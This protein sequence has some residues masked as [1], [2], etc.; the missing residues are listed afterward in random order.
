MQLGIWIKQASEFDLRFQRVIEMGIVFGAGSDRFYGMDTYENP[1]KYLKTL[2]FCSALFD[3][4]NPFQYVYVGRK[5]PPLGLLLQDSMC[6]F[7]KI[8]EIDSNC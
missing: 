7:S 3:L 1:V 5:I 2:F 4:E 6:S 8:V